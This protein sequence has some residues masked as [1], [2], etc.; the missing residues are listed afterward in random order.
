MVPKKIFFTKGVGKDREKLRSFELALRDAGIQQ[1]NLVNVSSIMPPKC[2]IVPR[3]QG[4]QELKA[5]R[6]SILCYGKK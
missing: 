4:L 1:F 5:G 6:D 2:K 3:A